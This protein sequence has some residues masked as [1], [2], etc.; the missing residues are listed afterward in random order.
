[1]Y[2]GVSPAGKLAVLAP[3]DVNIFSYMLLHFLAFVLYLSY[4][5]LAWVAVLVSFDIIVELVI[6][7][8]QGQNFITY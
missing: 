7:N 6:N 4:C 3:Q 2:R 8:S 1:M 5:S